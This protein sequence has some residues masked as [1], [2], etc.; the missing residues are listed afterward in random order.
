MADRVLNF[1]QIDTSKIQFV[2]GQ[3]VTPI[4]TASGTSLRIFG[5]IEYE[6]GPLRVQTPFLRTQRGLVTSEFGDKTEYYMELSLLPPNDL[7]SHLPVNAPFVGKFIEFFEGVE[8]AHCVSVA[9]NLGKWLKDG[10]EINEAVA[11]A[12][13]NS[14]IKRSDDGYPPKFN[15]RL[16]TQIDDEGKFTGGQVKQQAFDLEADKICT[17]PGETEPKD[18]TIH[19]IE[20]QARLR[21][22]MVAQSWYL[23]YDSTDPGKCKFGIKWSFEHI[24]FYNSPH[25][26]ASIKTQES[27]FTSFGFQDMTEDTLGVF[28]PSAVTVTLQR[29]DER[30]IN[31][32]DNPQDAKKRKIVV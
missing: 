7:N 4:S 27:V 21:I 12:M 29:T 1:T 24:L 16:T 30:Q 2:P 32:E 5:K 23:F 14:Q 25:L 19:D 9:K 17:L 22:Q 8:N 20:K 3:N 6:N 15:F 10:T 13:Q 31:L 26:D 11:V 18:V 28:D